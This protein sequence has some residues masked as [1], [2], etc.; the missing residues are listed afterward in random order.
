MT[1]LAS[2]FVMLKAGFKY[3]QITTKE[4]KV[5]EGAYVV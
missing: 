3:D 1:S 5:N 2:H 4:F